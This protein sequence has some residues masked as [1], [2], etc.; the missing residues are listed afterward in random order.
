MTQPQNEGNLR[1]MKGRKMSIKMSSEVAVA[2]NS[3]HLLW[4]IVLPAVILSKQY[5]LWLSSCAETS[6]RALLEK[7]GCF[8]SLIATYG[9]QFCFASQRRASYLY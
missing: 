2:L 4:R 6:E 7:F 1:F 9:P 5:E 8:C 3:E